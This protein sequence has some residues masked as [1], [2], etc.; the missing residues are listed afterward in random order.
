MAAID[1]TAHK[2]T[3]SEHHIGLAEWY[4]LCVIGA[5]PVPDQEVANSVVCLSEGDPRG[6]VSLAE[7]RQA[8]KRCL[9]REWL[10]RVEKVHLDMI[11]LVLKKS[12]AIGPIYGLPSIGDIDFTPA[13]AR[14]FLTISELLIGTAPPERVYEI[15]HPRHLFYFPTKR[16]AQSVVRRVRQRHENA[17]FGEVR[18]IGPW[19]V[20]WWRE[21]PRGYTVELQSS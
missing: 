13:G 11:E 1:P 18:E 20:Y 14:L 7:C 15:E 3:L 16:E 10:M 8:L 2:V 5:W 21:Y 6:S 9:A 4:T 17:R 19:R 12:P